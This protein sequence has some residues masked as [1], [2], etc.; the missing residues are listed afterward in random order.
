MVTVD[1]VKAKL[2]KYI[3]DKSKPEWR[4]K[5]LCWDGVKRE[6]PDGLNGEVLLEVHEEDG[7][8]K[9][10]ITVTLENLVNILNMRDD[11]SLRPDIT[12]DFGKHKGRRL[13]DLTSAEFEDLT[14]YKMYFDKWRR[15]GVAI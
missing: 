9:G 13:R 11:P 14:G 12:I 1:E 5:R 10:Y 4:V 7:K 8:V 3:V 15:E 6:I 2:A